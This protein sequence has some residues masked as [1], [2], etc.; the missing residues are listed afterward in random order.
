MARVAVL[1][2]IAGCTE[3]PGVT[4][5]DPGPEPDA[6]AMTRL[7]SGLDAPVFLTAPPG[8]TRA[9]VVEQPGRIRVLRG[10]SVRPTPFLDITDRVR[11]GGERGLL[12][13]AF[14]P[15]YASNGLFFVYYTRSDGASRV[16]RFEVGADPDLAD[17][18]SESVVLDVPQPFSN[19]NGGMMAFGPGG[20]LF[21]ALGDGGGAGDPN[22]NGQDTDTLLGSLLRIDVDGAQPYAIPPGNPFASGGGRPEIWALGLRNP[23]RFSIDVPTGRIWIGDVG[24]DRAEEINRR[25]LADAGVNYGWSITEGS[26]CFQASTCD[27]DGLAAPF[28][29]YDHDRGCSVIGGYVYRGDAAPALRGQYFFSDF[30]AGFLHSLDAA[31]VAPEPV[32][33]ATP[34]LG[35]VLS[36]GR[37]AAGEVYVLTAAGD[38]WRIDGLS[39]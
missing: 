32:E 17:P 39:D 8:D 21:I 7:A 33:W 35:R 3:G 19:H 29:S 12:G 28:H 27:T 10:G 1:L 25:S 14:H 15:A 16:A 30:C 5:P 6:L 37:D 38:I 24:Q 23:W 9:F 18:G 31:A 36:L 26:D 13:L 11:A 22:G 4:V 34:E 2:T 20:E